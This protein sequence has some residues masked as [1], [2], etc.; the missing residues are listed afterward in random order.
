MIGQ[1]ASVYVIVD[2]HPI[3]KAKLVR[4]YAQSLG[5]RLRLIYLLSCSLRINPDEKVWAHIKRQESK[6]LVQGQEKVK[7]LALGA[8]RRIQRLATLV[9]SSFQQPECRY[10]VMWHSFMKTF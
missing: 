10:A 2:G 8:L 7:R 3:H 1:K 9:K 5:R 4:N 6:R